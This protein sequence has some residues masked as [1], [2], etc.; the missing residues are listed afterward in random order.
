MFPNQNK[1][2][3]RKAKTSHRGVNREY[4][5][6][7]DLEAGELPRRPFQAL[8]LSLLGSDG[9]GDSHAVVAGLHRAKI[10]QGV[11]NGNLGVALALSGFQR[12]L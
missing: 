8:S 5:L 6:K 7:Q 4:P 12:D 1:P 10:K 3:T 11:A 9:I 2:H